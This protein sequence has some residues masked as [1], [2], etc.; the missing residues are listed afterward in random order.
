[1]YE[2]NPYPLDVYLELEPLC[3]KGHVLLVQNREDRQLYVKKR[4]RSYAP[5][6]YRLLREEPVT[7][8]PGIYGIYP[9]PE[10]LTGS[11]EGT[12]LVIIEEYLPG[13]TLAEHLRDHGPFSEA[14]VIRI[15]LELCCILRELHSRRPAIVHRDIKPE[16]VMLLPDGSVELLDF[17]A[18]KLEAARESRDTVLMGT[19][20]FAAPEQ[21]GFSSSTPQTDLY[22]MGVL[23]N[24]LRTG[25]LPWNTR[26]E[27]QLRRVIDRCLQIHPA[28]RYPS[29]DALRRALKA[30]RSRNIPWLPP[31]FRTMKWYK[32]SPASAFY[33][34]MIL[35]TLRPDLKTGSIPAQSVG[36]YIVQSSIWLLPVL[37]YCDYLGF[38]KHFPPM[39]S[40]NR[41]VRLLGLILSPL[42]LMFLVLS[43]YMFASIFGIL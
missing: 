26:A 4:V 3:D 35:L 42:W 9:D 14:E 5:E 27:G 8:T 29:A 13:H 1:M 41:W 11:A 30:A 24:T 16:N 25:Q 6:L 28:D 36:D 38:Q 7:K 12:A 21:Y 10:H 22:S 17:S 34:L 43:L 32:A 20:G 31:G 40:R 2:N 18:S 15:G 37:F 23:L 19:A 33:C 39:R